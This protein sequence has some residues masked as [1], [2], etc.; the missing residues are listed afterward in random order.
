[1]LDASFAFP[2]DGDS[3]DAKSKLVFRQTYLLVAFSSD[4]CTFSFGTAVEG[5][6]DQTAE[7]GASRPC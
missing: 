5:R 2:E 4:F 7:R 1:M 6:A 3:F